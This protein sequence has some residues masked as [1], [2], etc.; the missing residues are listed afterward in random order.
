M[1]VGVISDTHGLLRPQVLELFQDVETIIHAGDI[2]NQ[3]VL[4]KLRRLAPVHA[5]HGNTDGFPLTKQFPSKK[6]FQ[7][8]NISVFLTHIGGSPHQMRSRYPEI[9]DSDLVI[10]GHSHK[11]LKVQDG[12]TLF[13][14]PG[15][16]GP[17]R[18][19]T[20]VT[21]GKIKISESDISVDIVEIIGS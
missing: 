3:D 15:S 7:L 4:T 5:V 19:S 18:L 13:F 21:L 12:H 17:V 14:N 16:A 11:P 10:F 6:S 20:P 1:L 2:G 8:Q 9:E